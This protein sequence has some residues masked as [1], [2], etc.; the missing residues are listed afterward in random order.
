MP[1]LHEPVRQYVKQ[2][3]PDK[4]IGFKRHDLAFVVISIVSPPEGDLIVFELYEPVVADRD[5]VGVSAEIFQNVLGLLEGLLCGEYILK[6][7]GCQVN[8]QEGG[9]HGLRASRTA[10]P[11]ERSERR[12]GRYDDWCCLAA[13]KSGF[14]RHCPASYFPLSLN[15]Q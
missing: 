13:D 12:K 6:S 14:H 1:D 2:E 15:V 5:P 3:P 9:W 10:I 8:F 7:V 4:L 11:D